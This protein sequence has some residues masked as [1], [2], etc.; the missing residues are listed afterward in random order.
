MNNAHRQ[1]EPYRQMRLIGRGN[2]VDVYEA[3]DNQ[4]KKHVLIKKSHSRLSQDDRSAFLGE[5]R[6]AMKLD[7]PHILKANLLVEDHRPPYLVL[8][9]ERT[10]SLFRQRHPAGAVLPPTLISRYAWQIAAALAYMHHN[11]LTH[12]HLRPE[13]LVVSENDDILLAD[14]GIRALNWQAGSQQIHQ[15]VN[16]ELYM[17]PELFLG[18]P[19]PVS[20]QYSLAA[21]IYEWFTGRP[22]LEGASDEIFRQ[23]FSTPPSLL[24]QETNQIPSTVKQPLLKALARNPKERF[25]SITAFVA[26]LGMEMATF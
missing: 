21:M 7:H 13:N 5:W 24:L 20:D 19:E 8:D 17:A 14:L 18:A 25:D 1:M 6:T 15:L 11:G 2:F 12:Q 22:L 4:L 10:Y 26:N 3:I 23:R 9:Y 16:V